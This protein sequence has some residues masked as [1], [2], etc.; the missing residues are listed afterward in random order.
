MMNHLSTRFV[1]LA[2]MLLV[3]VAIGA[4]LRTDAV[5]QAIKAA[6]VKNVDEPGRLPRE[7]TAIF[8]YDGCIQNCSGFT[9]RGPTLNPDNT[10][11]PVGVSFDLNLGGQPGGS[12]GQTQPVVPSGKRWV[13]E[14]ISGTVPS[15]Y[16]WVGVLLS[17]GGPPI[18]GASG[19]PKWAYYGPYNPV[20]AA[21][22]NLGTGKSL[23][24]SSRLFTT[25]NAGEDMVVSALGGSCGDSGKD[26]SVCSP[27]KYSI[28]L[29]GYLIDNTN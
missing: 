9:R 14:S 12:P 10:W 11:S 7:I 13:V 27:L 19:S 17:P 5:A 15:M 21:I 3:V 2:L 26:V 25:L 29:S 20:P 23:G 18:L 28:T 4:A 6:L 1:K 22:L 24:F 16:D 8:T